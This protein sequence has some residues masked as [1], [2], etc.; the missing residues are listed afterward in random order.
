MQLFAPRLYEYYDTTLGALCDRDPYLRRNFANNVF[1]NATFN[2]GPQTTSLPHHDLLNLAWGWCTITAAGSFDPTRSGHIVLWE[3]RMV[4]EFPAGSTILIPSAI[5]R[6]SNTRVAP[7]ERRY[8]FTQ[9]SAGG[10]FRWVEA[11]FKPAKLLP[12]TSAKQA[13][14]EGRE[15]WERGVSM[16]SMWSEFSG[17][18]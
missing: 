9:Y 5:I 14:Q 2:L 3:L 17:E 6:H 13:R 1:G 18:E 12:R 7:E 4:I 15:R 16:L 8:S 10:L 11:G